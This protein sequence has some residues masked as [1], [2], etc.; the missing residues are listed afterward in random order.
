MDISLN[1][2]L[3]DE[4]FNQLMEKSYEKIFET[5]EFTVALRESIV[6]QV[7]DHLTKNPKYIERALGVTNDWS[8][9]KYKEHSTVIS[10]I[11][12]TASV[13][14]CKEISDGV[15]DVLKDVVKKAPID[16][17]IMD[18][19]KDAVL[20]GLVSGMSRHIESDTVWKSVMYS[21]VNRMKEVLNMN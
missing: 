6:K 14:Y 11:V 7:S 19:I 16:E 12:K 17:I 13:E 5:D 9:D 1:V 18:I 10:G 4:Q 3:T 2:Q 8:Y 15:T 21:E 20:K